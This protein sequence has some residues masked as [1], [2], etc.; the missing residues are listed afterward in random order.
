ME[1][2]YVASYYNGIQFNKLNAPATV[3][4]DVWPFDAD[5]YILMNMAIQ[6]TWGS[7][8]LSNVTEMT[9]EIDYVRV[10]QHS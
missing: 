5:F 2:T 10:S 9:M 1:P 3:N 8:P 4:H 6:P 7:K